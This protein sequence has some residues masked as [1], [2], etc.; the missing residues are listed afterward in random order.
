MKK[1][2]AHIKLVSKEMAKPGDSSHHL[3]T[4]K[5]AK[6]LKFLVITFLLT[7]ERGVHKLQGVLPVKFPVKTGYTTH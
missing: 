1:W 4:I 3:A 5:R 2:L 6:A 7:K